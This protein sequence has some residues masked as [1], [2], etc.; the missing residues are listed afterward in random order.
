VHQLQFGGRIQ[1]SLIILFAAAVVLSF[2]PAA[3]A[4]MSGGGVGGGGVSGGGGSSGGSRGSR[5]QNRKPRPK[6]HEQPPV[7]PEAAR[8]KLQKA[9]EI[10]FTRGTAGVSYLANLFDQASA[11]DVPA[12]SQSRRALAEAISTGLK[13][14]KLEPDVAAGIAEPLA[15]MINISGLDDEE[16]DAKKGLLAE[17]LAAAGI[18]EEQ[19][20]ETMSAIDQVLAD[21]KDEAVRKIADALNEIQ[22]EGTVSDDQKKNLAGHVTALASEPAPAEAAVA[23]L[24]DDMGKGLDSAQLTAK[25]RAQLGFDLRQI[26]GSG[27]MK[28]AELMPLVNQVK[29]T[30]KA[31]LVKQA[32]IQAIG[33]DL[34]A[35]HKSLSHPAPHDGGPPPVESSGE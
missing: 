20:A 26:L 18:A 12:S 14:L 25:E 34:M 1:G 27:Q 4:Q 10:A 8:T 7:D 11:G 5:D 16:V 24:A 6:R 15:M 33:N 3:S 17:A 35:I 28:P 19:V 23:K 2:A 32:D 21:Q 22:K 29:A 30:L 13:G 31:G 9:M